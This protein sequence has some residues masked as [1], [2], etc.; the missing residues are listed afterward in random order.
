MSTTKE[1]CL[2]I[3]VSYRVDKIHE[4]EEICRNGN[5]SSISLDIDALEDDPRNILRNELNASKSELSKFKDLLEIILRSRLHSLSIENHVDN[6]F[7]SSRIHDVLEEVL[8]KKHVSLSCLRLGYCKRINHITVSSVAKLLKN[9]N[10]EFVELGSRYAD[11]KEILEALE[12]NRFVRC[13][14]L[15]LGG[16]SH[17]ELFSFIAK[18]KLMVLSLSEIR[19]QDLN[20]VLSLDLKNLRILNIDKVYNVKKSVN[21]EN[22]IVRFINSTSIRVFRLNFT[23]ECNDVNIE[24]VLKGLD[25]NIA[26]RYIEINCDL[27][28]SFDRASD[29]FIT[30]RRVRNLRCIKVKTFSIEYPLCNA[31]YG[32][33]A[34]NELSMKLL[35]INSG[36][37]HIFFDNFCQLDS[38][39]CMITEIESIRRDTIKDEIS[40]YFDNS[41]FSDLKLSVISGNISRVYRLH[42]VIC[43]KYI[44][45]DVIYEEDLEYFEIFLKF[46]YGIGSISRV[47]DRDRI[48]KIIEKYA[49]D[50]MN[51]A[52]D[53]I[54]TRYYRKLMNILTNNRISFNK[55]YLIRHIVDGITSLPNF[56]D[57]SDNSLNLYRYEKDVSAK[58]TDSERNTS[59]ESNTR[60]K[61][62]DVTIRLVDDL[63]QNGSVYEFH[64]HRVILSSRNEYFKGLFSQSFRES[65]QSVITICES[66]KTGFRYLIDFI[67]KKFLDLSDIHNMD[68]RMRFCILQEIVYVADKYLCEPLKRI[69]EVYLISELRHSITLMHAVNSESVI[70]MAHN[71]GLRKLMNFF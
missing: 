9:C 29:L 66:N 59:R 57:E 19:S 21:V 67:Y 41:R 62:S 48:M 64:C 30:L 63:N 36:R 37:Y 13:L 1:D 35:L 71:F 55:N 39:N 44:K 38:I 53:E 8:G 5:V 23:M 46:L 31:L 40:S 60:G 26:T 24:S 51:A 16:I 58:D 32:N 7:M 61:D 3:R 10:V 69:A 11:K 17:N 20:R 25:P 52:Q 43:S 15:S 2:G 33:E 70:R 42:K 54:E 56:T 12:A 49:P 22:S 34:E 18:D 27:K 4:I 14:S 65:T 68:S 47:E 28:L 6:S 50:L 45:E